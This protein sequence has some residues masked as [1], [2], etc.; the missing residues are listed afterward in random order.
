[1]AIR[2]ALDYVMPRLALCAKE[3]GVKN[4]WSTAPKKAITKALCPCSYSLLGG[5]FAPTIKSKGRVVVS[6]TYI[7]RILIYPFSA[8]LSDLNDGSEANMRALEFETAAHFYYQSHEYLATAEESD[9]RF[10]LG[11]MGVTDSGLVTRNAPGGGKYAALDF[12]INIVMA[13]NAD[14]FSSPYSEV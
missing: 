11:I 10:C 12:A 5:T 13:A 9:L 4:A 3:F 8:G 14:Q 2:F 1:M 7:Q 6:R